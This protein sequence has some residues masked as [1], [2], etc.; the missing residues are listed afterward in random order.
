MLHTCFTDDSEGSVHVF[1]L[2]CRIKSDGVRACQVRVSMAVSVSEAIN[3]A[4]GD[5]G[6]QPSKAIELVLEHATA[7]FGQEPAY[8]LFLRKTVDPE[9]DGGDGHVPDDVMSRRLF[10]K[11][12]DNFQAEDLLLMQCCA[13]HLRALGPH[14]SFSA[15]V[16]RLRAYVEGK[17]ARLSEGTDWA[18][19]VSSR[20][21]IF[22]E[23]YRMVLAI[24]V[25]MPGPGL[26]GGTCCLMHSQDL[27]NTCISSLGCTSRWMQA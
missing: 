14:S 9:S 17:A 10:E 2:Q 15:A 4:S 21:D 27:H 19:G 23:M 24:Y 22:L 6:V 18:G 26:G 7:Q 3:G 16:G 20:S 25:A 8:I 1:M 13:K 11:E 12:C 5:A